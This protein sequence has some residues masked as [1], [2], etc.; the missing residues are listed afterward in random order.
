MFDKIM[1]MYYKALSYLKT[2]K[3]Q[4]LVEYALILVLIAIVVIAMLTATGKNVN[5]AFSKINSALE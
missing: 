1:E 2:E 3:G 5:N 4:A